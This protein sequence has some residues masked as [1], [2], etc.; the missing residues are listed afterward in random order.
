M[1][2]TRVKVQFAF[3]AI[4]LLGVAAG[5]LS[6]MVY[7]RRIETGH[8]SAWTGKF[9]RERY[10]KQMTEAVRLRSDQMSQL[11]AILDDTRALDEQ[12][13]RLVLRHLV[14]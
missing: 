7:Y 4:F 1:D 13:D 8:Q 12:L 11:E 6:L 5:A 2:G 9:D 3:L 10:V 14:G